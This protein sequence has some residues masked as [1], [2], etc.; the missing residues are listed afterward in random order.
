[1]IVSEHPQ[2]SDEWHQER[3]GLPTASC[4]KKIITTRGNPSEQ[5]EKY[6]DE[7]AR[8]YLTGRATH[9]FVSQKMREKAEREADARE[10]YEFVYRTKVQQVGL[11]WK[12]E[13]KM[14]GASPDGLIDL[15]GGFETKDA[16]P[17]VQVM[18][19]RTKWKGMEYFQQV[20]GGM[21]VC[22][23]KWWDL[24]SYCEGMQPITIR[25]KRDPVFIKKLE[26]ELIKFC[27]QLAMVVKKIKE[28]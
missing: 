8:E 3:L 11:C 17:N 28:A 13:R 26:A 15:D 14:F 24:Q 12:D 7:L 21:F 27:F 20:Q 4:F 1:M 10:F 5:R 23:R 6:L 16:D 18:R 19:I 2:Q 25:F 9:R 22:N